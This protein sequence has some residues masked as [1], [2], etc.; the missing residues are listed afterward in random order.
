M[1]MLVKAGS[2]GVAE[3]RAGERASHEVDVNLTD[4]K[5]RPTSIDE[6]STVVT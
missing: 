1:A 3:K 5:E 2:P 4:S 6:L